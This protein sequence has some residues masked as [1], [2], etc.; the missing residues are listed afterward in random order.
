MKYCAIKRRVLRS[1]K[2]DAIELKIM[3]QVHM[4]IATFF[5]MTGSVP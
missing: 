5:T 3:R 2:R 1:W 4:Q